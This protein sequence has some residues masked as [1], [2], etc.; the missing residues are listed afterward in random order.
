MAG[1]ARAQVTLDQRVSELSRQIS[2]GLTENQKR[3]IAVV[4]FVD[5]KGNVTDFGRFLAEELI[6]RLYQT[7]KF[8]VIERQLLNKVVTEQK[9][10]LTGMIDQTSAQKLG[11]LLGV[12]AIAS[13]TITDLGKSLR[14]NARLIDTTTGE[15]F[16][17]ASAEIVKDDVVAKLMGAPDVSAKETSQPQSDSSKPGTQKIEAQFFTFELLHCKKSGTTVICDLD[18][19]NKERDRE[20]GTGIN[21]QLF[22]DFGN[23]VNAVE[24]RVANKNSGGMGYASSLFVAGVT[25]RVRV[26]FQNVAP[27]ATKATLLDLQFYIADLSTFQVRFR[28]VALVK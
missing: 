22:D 10:S 2:D 13:G 15:I 5:L 25:T 19:T 3:T 23:K 1:H 7:K 17:V 18:I 16:A 12:D 20:L 27:Q 21:S 24:V 14:V 28:G 4:E 9:L 6:T 11:K 8:K 26:G